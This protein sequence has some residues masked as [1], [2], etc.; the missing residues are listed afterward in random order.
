MTSQQDYKIAL[1]RFQSNRLRRDHADLAAE[2]Q[3]RDI[4]E[5]F[6][7]EMYGPRDFSARDEQAR[8]LHQFVHLVPGIAVGDVQ[9]VLELLELSNRLDDGLVEVLLELGAPINF[10]EQI[11][12]RAYRLADNYAERVEQID[13]ARDSLYNVYRMAR[14]PFVGLALDRIQGLAQRVGMADIHRFLRQGFAAIQPVR[15]IHRFVETVML[16][17]QDRLDRI[18]DC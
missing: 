1:Q 12:E 13:L 14:R 5:F 17:E 3:Y 4:G 8:R 16:R 2:P 15:D 7:E 6:F 9:K 10:D 18:Y 11:Y